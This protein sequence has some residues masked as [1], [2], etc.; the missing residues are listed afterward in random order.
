[1]TASS[2]CRCDRD[3][4]QGLWRV[5]RSPAF[6]SPAFAKSRTSK[7]RTS[8]RRTSGETHMTHRKKLIEV[9]L[10]LEAINQA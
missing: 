1:M 3:S 10:P 8:K 6:R 7:S 2:I 4:R 9:A 5:E